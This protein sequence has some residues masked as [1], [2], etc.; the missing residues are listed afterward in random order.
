MFSGPPLFIY[1]RSLSEK[2]AVADLLTKVSM[3][4]RTFS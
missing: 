3:L 2:A 4:V 1:M